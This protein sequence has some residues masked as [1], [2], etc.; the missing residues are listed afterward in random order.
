MDAQPLYFKEWDR[1]FLEHRSYLIAFAFRMT[2]SLAESEDLVQDVFIESAKVDPSKIENHKAWLTKICS[3]RALDLLKSAYKQRE[4]YPGTWLPDAVPESL[5]SWSESFIDDSMEKKFLLS[6]SLTTSFLILLER[7]NPEERAIYLLSEIFDYSFKEIAEMLDK[8][9]ASCRKIAQRARDFIVAN[10]K[11]F[12][13]KSINP[14]EM[15]AK[16]FDLASHGDAAAL[17]QMLAQDS[18]FWSDG[19]G[20]VAAVPHIVRTPHEIARFFAGIYSSPQAK[21]IEG[22]MEPHQINGRPGMVLSRKLASGEWILETLLSFE[23]DG[24]KIIRIYAQR[25]PDKLKSLMP[26]N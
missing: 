4:T 5:Q 15:I 23:F 3:H 1:F 2:G 8:S 19:G 9:E 14:T 26:K 18:E 7:L 13:P 6:E 17:S 16:F 25:N 21:K 20:K 24:D 10:R 12:E 11:R 22:K